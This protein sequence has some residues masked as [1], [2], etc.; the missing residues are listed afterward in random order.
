MVSV[1]A[2]GSKYLGAKRGFVVMVMQRCRCD[3]SLFRFFF[4]LESSL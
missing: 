4:A 1:V 3:M 2:D